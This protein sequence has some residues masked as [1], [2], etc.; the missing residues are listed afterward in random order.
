[1][2]NEKKQ[3]MIKHLIDFLHRKSQP[4]FRTLEEL[5]M[6]PSVT[7]NRW[8][9][10]TEGPHNERQAFRHIDELFPTIKL[11]IPMPAIKPINLWL[12]DIDTME[13]QATWTFTHESQIE[14]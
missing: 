2:N 8:E 9:H 10:L 7:V 5:V 6:R 4:S 1:M 14:D 13:R 3:K 12:G 11:N